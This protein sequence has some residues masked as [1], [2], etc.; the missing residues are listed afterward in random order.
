MIHFTIHLREA[1]ICSKQFHK[2]AALS[3][4]FLVQ[5][6]GFFSEA[7]KAIDFIALVC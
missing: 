4:C 7:P 2:A 1:E 6:D 3:P 5:P